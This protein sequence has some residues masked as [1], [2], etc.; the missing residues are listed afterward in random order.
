MCQA[1]CNRCYRFLKKILEKS[2]LYNQTN[3]CLD[4]GNYRMTKTESYV[5]QRVIG[6]KA[7]MAV[8][9]DGMYITVEDPETKEC[10]VLLDACSGAAVSSIGHHHKEAI[11]ASKNALGK[12]VYTY[13]ASIGNYAAEDLAKFICDHSD[14]AF[15]SA[16]FVGS[17]SEAN[18]NALKVMKQYH[19]ENGEPGRYKFISRIQ[20]YHGYT[21][22]TLSLGDGHN[23]KCQF[24]GC[25]LSYDQTTKVSQCYPYRNLMENETLEQYAGRLIAELEQ[26]II[27]Q[28]PEK[29]AGVIFETVGGS[30]FGT[31]VPIPG[32]LDGCKAVCEK[33]GV[34]FML[35][36]VMCGLGRCGTYHAW[37]QFMT[38]GPDVQTVGKTIGNGMV[39]LA[40]VLVSP[41]VKEVYENGS[42]TVFGAQTYH[43]HDF[44]CRVGLE[45]Q[46]I[47]IREK[48]VENCMKNGTLMSKLLEEK[49]KNSKMVGQ[50]RGAG[51]FWSIEFVKDKET[52]E[53][54]DPKLGICKKVTATAYKNGLI[55]MSQGGT[56]DGLK[57]DHVTIAPAY[58]LSEKDAENIATILSQSILETEKEL[59]S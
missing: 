30:T 36:E 38:S 31:Q 11:E 53:P 32:Y 42:G 47:V 58:I 18:E 43:S 41:K 56:I 1:P 7:P 5:F 55:C 22:A 28:G 37:Q 39:T 49:L 33:H 27:K 40:G 15:A 12:A 59:F 29:V 14:G 3:L 54:F 57:G 20:S 26:T 24:E 19:Y 44:N 46:K 35:D 23:R 2:S 16:L 13:G 6:E 50:I 48:L 51:T 52:K 45:V 8:D 4:S 9:A 21:L 17:G 25:F 34:L 10:R